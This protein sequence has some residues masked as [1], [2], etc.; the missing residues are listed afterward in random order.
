MSLT[1]N[2]FQEEEASGR[3]W[4]TFLSIGSHAM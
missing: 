2:G 1:M 4:V 3:L